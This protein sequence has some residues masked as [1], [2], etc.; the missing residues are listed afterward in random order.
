MATAQTN[1][2]KSL[3]FLSEELMLKVFANTILIRN[4][5]TYKAPEM[6]VS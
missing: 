6:I 3:A 5:V 4:T 2:Y 1:K